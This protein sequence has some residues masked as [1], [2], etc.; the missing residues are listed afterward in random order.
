[1]MRGTMKIKLK[2]KEVFSNSDYT[3][4]RLVSNELQCIGRNVGDPN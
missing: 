1:M 4:L 2:K 3:V